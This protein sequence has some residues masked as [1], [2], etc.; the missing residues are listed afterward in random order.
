MVFLEPVLFN[1]PWKYS[2][3]IF[4]NYLY[5]F[6]NFNKYSGLYKNKNKFFKNLLIRY[7]PIILTGYSYTVL[8]TN[9]YLIKCLILL[10]NYNYTPLNAYFYTSIINLLS[11][12]FG[13]LN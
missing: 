8:K 3:Y 1:F 9:T 13:D 4:Y 11:G 6:L 10:S 5:F 2:Y 7:V 12:L